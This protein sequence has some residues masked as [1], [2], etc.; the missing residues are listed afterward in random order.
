[1]RFLRF[2]LLLICWEGGN[3]ITL[4]MAQTTEKVGNSQKLEQLD[5]K[6]QRLSE[7]MRD[8]QSEYGALQEALRTQEQAIA[9]ATATLLLLKSGL[10]DKEAALRTL[11]QRKTLQVNQLT[12]LRQ[13]LAKQ[14]HAT[15]V[16]GQQDYLKLWLNQQ[17]PTTVG[18]L[19]TYYDYFNQARLQQILRLRQ[20]MKEL[21]NIEHALTAENDELQQLLNEQ[22]A[23]KTVLETAQQQRQQ[24]LVQVS[25]TLS[26][27]KQLLKAL[28][29]ERDRLTLLVDD[30]NQVTKKLE[31]PPQTRPF[32]Q[33]KGQLT[34][35]A[36]GKIIHQ[37]GEKRVGKLQWQ[38]IGIAASL[39]DNVYA[40]ADG[41]VVFAEWFRTLGLLVIIDHGDGFM[42][43][44]GYNQLL[45][46]KQGD[47]IK[48]G[49]ILAT[50]GNSG[51]LTDPMLYFEIRQQGNPVNPAQWLAKINSPEKN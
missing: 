22:Q 4:A 45:K 24:T 14:I 29:D 18:R 17:D 21:E 15:Y 16:V 25:R 39:G 48:A 3:G 1:M 51:G 35:P 9:E 28:Q 23:K 20:A 26:N 38:G 33:L 37:F 6:I 49:T 11:N 30:L 31:F 32:N 8:T 46:V 50:V 2:M 34:Q 10:D 12:E 47:W 27:Q 42:S 19:L 44:Y 41:R 43:L 5:T 40:V 13:T 7:Q 36:V